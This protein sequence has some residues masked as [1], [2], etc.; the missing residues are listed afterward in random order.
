MPKEI[1]TKH[2]FKD[3]KLLDKAA[4]GT[5]HAKNVIIRSKDAAEETQQS[6]TENPANC[7]SN[8]MAD[9]VQS[10]AQEVLHHFKN[11]QQKVAENLTKAKE[12]FQ[13]TRQ[14]LVFVR[15]RTS[16]AATYAKEKT[17]QTG[18]KAVRHAKGSGKGTVKTARKS[19]KSAGKPPKSRLKQR[20]RQP[21]RRSLQ[22]LQKRLHR[23]RHES[24][25]LRLNQQSKRQKPLE[26]RSL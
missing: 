10:A 18:W 17:R 1:K 4:S 15:K 7:A 6:Q 11:P 19:V 23:Q 20:I 8:H 3:I 21:Q 5:A 26:K 12:Q 16:N 25:K 13:R 9:G 2:T 24:P 14:Q 22:R